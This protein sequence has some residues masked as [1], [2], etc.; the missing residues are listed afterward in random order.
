[1]KKDMSIPR[2]NKMFWHTARDDPM[3]TTIRVISKHQTTQIYCAI[4]LKQLTNQAMIESEAYKTYY[5]YATGEKS[6]KP[7]YVQ[8][9]A[10]FKTS[11]KKKP[12]QA[13]KGKRLKATAKT[14]SDNDG[15]DFVHPKLSTFDKEERH[16]E[17]K[18]E[19]EE[20]PDE[21]KT[22][23]EE[24]VNELYRDVNVNLEGRDTEMTDALLPNFQVTQFIEDTHVIM[25]AVTPEAQQQSSS[26][27]SSFISNMLN[28]NPDTGIDSILNLNIE[29]TSLVDVPITTNLEMPLSSVT[30]LP[31]PPILLFEDRV[32]TL[33]DNFSEF[34]QTNLFVEAI[35]S[36]PGIV[37]TYLANKINEAV[38]TAVHVQSDRHRDEAQAENVDFINKLDEN[39]K[40]IIKE[41]VKVQVK[42]QVFKILPKIKKLVNEQL[43]A[44]VLT[45]L[46]NK[47][48]TSHSV[49]T[50]LSELELREILIDKIENV[51]MIRMMTKNPPLDQTGG[52][53]RRIAGKEPESTNEPNE[54]T[55]KST[56]KSKEGPKSHQKS[57]G[58]FAQADEPI[59]TANDLEE[60]TPQ[61]FNIG[62]KR[63]QFY[64]FAVN[65]ES[66]RDVYSRHKIIAVTKLQIVKWHNYKHL[67]WIT[68]RRDDDKLYTFKE[69]DYKRLCLQDIKD[70]M[71]LLVQ[72]KLTNL[73]IEERLALN[74][75]LRMFT[76]S[77][78]I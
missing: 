72:G 9:K 30:T 28:P 45:R 5:V 40:K 36:I 8:K 19:E 21:E 43:E 20:E 25:T 11:P 63:Q 61:E 38:K 29:S 14:E 52:S 66:A 74:V 27:S 59:H 78:V 16:D 17:K 22:N 50:N 68:I 33:E 77:I 75:S 31:S 53:K 73:T 76:R 39:I 24:E 64:G 26:V 70:M 57:T 56:G 58:K 35:S 47:D 65:R 12:V 23:K 37:D 67:D 4:L 55:S 10:D 2:R 42:E 71:L 1:M 51:K 54:K 15:D 60:P 18:D 41:Q 62:R 3:F 69:G 7:K 49:A 48:K 13:P 32:K 44:E 6:P 46:S 34:K